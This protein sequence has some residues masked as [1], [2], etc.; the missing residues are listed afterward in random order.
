MRITKS[1]IIL[2]CNVK[3]LKQVF[4]N[5]HNENLIPDKETSQCLGDIGQHRT[6]ISF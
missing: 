3:I 5:Q 4:K 2:I 6:I 1:V